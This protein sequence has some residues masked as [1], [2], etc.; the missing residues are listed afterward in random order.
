[1]ILSNYV[2]HCSLWSGFLYYNLTITHREGIFFYGIELPNALN[3]DN[4]GFLIIGC[5]TYKRKKEGAKM[6]VIKYYVN[7]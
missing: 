1:M 3:I 6:F 5:T 7:K 4:E 2:T